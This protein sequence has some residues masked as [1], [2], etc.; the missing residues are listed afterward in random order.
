M[1]H[2]RGTRSIANARTAAEGT[3]GLAHPRFCPV[4]AIAV[5]VVTAA[6][7]SPTQSAGREAFRPASAMTTLLP[8]VVPPYETGAGI[9]PTLADHYAWLDTSVLTNHQLF[10]FM[11]GTGG[12]PAHQ[13]LLQQEAAHLGYHVIGLMYEDGFNFNDLCAGNA[14]LNSCFEN[15]SFDVVYGCAVQPCPGSVVNVSVTNSVV[16]LLTKLLEYLGT[17]YPDEG[18]ADFLADGKPSW[19]H[20]AVAGASQGGANAAMIAKH[21][22][23]ARVALFSA[24]ADA[25]PLGAVPCQGIGGW[26]SRHVTSSARYFGLAHDRDSYFPYICASWNSLGMDAFGAIVVPETSSPPYG[27]THELVTDLRPQGGYKYTHGST[28][29]DLRTPLDKNGNPLLAPVW[30]YMLTAAVTP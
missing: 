13:Q 12:L 25:L 11:P 26:L 23:V 22:L 18:W 7:G 9:D 16:N 10:V 3:T 8:H 28:S 14:D 4:V 30:D 20:V 29:N 15:A 21:S 24:I 19:S 6:C 17:N 27:G 2:S 5:V 1:T